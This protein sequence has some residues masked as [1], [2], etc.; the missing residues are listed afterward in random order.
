[1]ALCL[2][3][4]G[5]ALGCFVTGANASSVADADAGELQPGQYLWN[6][7]L[8]R[9]G[10]MTMLV[11]LRA[12][13][14]YVYRDGVRIGVTTISSGKPGYETPTGTF[15]VLEKERDHHSNK[16]DDAPMPY[17]ERLTW[18]GLALHG[19][20][21]RAHPS[22]HGCIR[23]PLSFA[24]ALYTETTRGMK[25]TITNGSAGDENVTIAGR[26]TA[27][28]KSRCCE[29][30]GPKPADDLRQTD[31][32]SGR[33]EWVAPTD[34]PCCQTPAGAAQAFQ[35]APP[36]CATDREA[37]EQADGHP[38]DDDVIEQPDQSQNDNCNGGPDQDQNLE[39]TQAVPQYTPPPPPSW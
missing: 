30:K 35:S 19:G 18:T 12:Q 29:A 21:V 39:R 9:S 36:E 10:P 34:E 24:A 7:S 28:P 23:L 11:N 15:T 5:T 13:R 20:H 16:Y 3:V 26:G 14:A 8:A 27:R 6:P 17:M 31:D 32:S 22:S 4:I 25:V 1:V 33:G 38:D 2:L 37:Y